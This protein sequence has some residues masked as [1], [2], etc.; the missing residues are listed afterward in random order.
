MEQHNW[1]STATDDVVDSYPISP[2]QGFVPEGA[3][4]LFAVPAPF[5][6]ARLFDIQFLLVF[7]SGYSAARHLP[8]GDVEA[9]ARIDG[10]DRDD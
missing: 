1:R 3:F 7:R 6:S 10:G 2:C 8:G 5:R 9:V 4:E